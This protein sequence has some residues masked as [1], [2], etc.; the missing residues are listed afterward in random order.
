MLAAILARQNRLE[1]ANATIQDLLRIRP[2]LTIARLT[3]AWRGMTP[4]VEEQLTEDL[5]KAGMPE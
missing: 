2:K 4:T 1:E 5:R 3:T